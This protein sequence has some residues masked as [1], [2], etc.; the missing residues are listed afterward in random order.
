MH[1]HF[2]IREVV[3]KVP[4]PLRICTYCVYKNFDRS[5]ASN[6]WLVPRSVNRWQHLISEIVFIFS[7]RWQDLNPELCNA[8]LS[9]LL[10][11]KWGKL[12]HLS[13]KVVSLFNPA[14]DHDIAVHIEL[15][16]RQQQGLFPEVSYHK[17]KS[18]ITL[19]GCLEWRSNSP[20]LTVHPKLGNKMRS[21]QT[22]G[23]PGACYPCRQT[24]KAS[25]H[26]RWFR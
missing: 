15:S 13:D 25:E 26:L 22:I 19:S 9:F 1:H 17:L 18:L 8:F 4:P 10:T 16:M 11:V 23:G 6:Y 3:P 2:W 5:P 14:T 12:G 21:S 7:Y 24:S 20:H